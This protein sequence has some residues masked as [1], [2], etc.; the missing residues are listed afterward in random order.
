MSSANLVSILQ[1]DMGLG[2]QVPVYP[3]VNFSKQ[4]NINK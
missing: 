4:A 3:S 2:H 1:E